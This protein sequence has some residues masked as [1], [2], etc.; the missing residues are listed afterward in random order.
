MIESSVFAHFCA[1]TSVIRSLFIFCVIEKTVLRVRLYIVPIQPRELKLPA[2]LLYAANFDCSTVSNT[3]NDLLGSVR[4]AFW[5]AVRS[6]IGQQ[7]ACATSRCIV[8]NVEVRC[9]PAVGSNV[10]DDDAD[11][12]A[13]AAAARRR[14]RRRTRQT[15][16][17]TQPTLSPQSSITEPSSRRRSNVRKNRKARRRSSGSTLSVQFNLATRLTP[18]SPSRWLEEYHFAVIRLRSVF[19]GLERQLALGGFRLDSPDAAANDNDRTLLAG[20]RV[21][22]DSLTDAPMKTMCDI[23]Y[24]SKNL[25]CGEMLY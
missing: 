5:S 2:E 25:F 17:T 1:L 15:V 23:G 7:G 14:R 24:M 12:A 18:T 4:N 10:A 21:I 13:A 8:D 16:S 6:Q 3:D 22:S 19:D 20:L 11:D 9:L